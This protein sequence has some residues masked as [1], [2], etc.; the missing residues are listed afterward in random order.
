MIFDIFERYLGS[1][2]YSRLDQDSFVEESCEKGVIHYPSISKKSRYFYSVLSAI[3][4][5]LAGVAGYLLGT[6]K[7][8]GQYEVGR[9]AGTVTQGK[10]S[11]QR[12]QTTTY[13][14]F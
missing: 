8:H 14:P 4:V 3:F 13:L 1:P 7:S 9:L 2:P 12:T 6:L 11:A 10:V 5:T